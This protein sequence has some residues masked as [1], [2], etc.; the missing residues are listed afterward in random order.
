MNSAFYG[1]RSIEHFTMKTLNL[2]LLAALAMVAAGCASVPQTTF[3]LN[4]KTG[5]LVVTSPKQV[6]AED[7]KAEFDR[8]SGF[9]FSVKKISSQNDAEILGAIAASNAAMAERVGAMAEKVFE[10]AGKGAVKAVAPIP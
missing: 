1:V 4:P 8:K 9:K 6:E 7:L 5:E 3:K 2:L 10:A